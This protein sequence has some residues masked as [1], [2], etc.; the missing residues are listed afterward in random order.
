MECYISV[1]AFR[2][3]ACEE[4]D[5]VNTAY[6]DFHIMIE[7]KHCHDVRV[8]TEGIVASHHHAFHNRQAEKYTRS[9]VVNH[10]VEATRE[11]IAA[12]VCTHC[13]YKHSIP[14]P[15]CQKSEHRGLAVI[16]RSSFSRL[17]PVESN[18]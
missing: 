1:Q 6:A 15:S 7:Q 2:N 11:K 17:E 9:I 8:P 10:F 18:V 4:E 12:I 16:M 3:L 5:K 13:D 14:L